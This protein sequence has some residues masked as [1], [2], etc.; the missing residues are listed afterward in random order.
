MGVFGAFRGV[1]GGT[2]HTTD[3]SRQLPNLRTSKFQSIV[4]ALSAR[5]SHRVCALPVYNPPSNANTHT[6]EKKIESTEQKRDTHSTLC[7]IRFH[8]LVQFFFVCLFFPLFL[9]PLFFFA[10]P[11]FQFSFVFFLWR[12]YFPHIYLTTTRISTLY[13]L[14]TFFS[15]RFPFF[16]FFFHFRMELC[17]RTKR[18]FPL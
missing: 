6:R 4:F 7:H 1:L 9:L 2:W 17:A 14:F 10:F 3:W 16:F 13:V 18:K 15:R 5:I 11:L 8:P 12:F